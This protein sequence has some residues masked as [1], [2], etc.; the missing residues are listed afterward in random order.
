MPGQA[1]CIPGQAGHPAA[2]AWADDNTFGVIQSPSMNASALA[3]ELRLMR[4]Q[5]EHAEK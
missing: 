4:P 3:A 2:C 5:V 1:A